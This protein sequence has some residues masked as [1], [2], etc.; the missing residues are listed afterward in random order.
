LQIGIDREQRRPGGD[1]IAL[2]HEQLLDAPDFVGADKHVVG[3]DPALKRGF[4]RLRV[5]SCH[6]KDGGRGQGLDC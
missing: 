6:H 5:P 3:L 4:D 2:A 1:D